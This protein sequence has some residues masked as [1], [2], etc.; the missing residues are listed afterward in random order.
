MSGWPITCPEC[1]GEKGFYQTAYRPRNASD[2][3]EQT[4]WFDCWYCNGTGC[5]DEDKLFE[6]EFHAP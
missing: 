2:D 4:V 6:D 3:K 1:D 5:V